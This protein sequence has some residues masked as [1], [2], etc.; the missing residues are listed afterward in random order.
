GAVVILTILAAMSYDPRLGWDADPDEA[1]VTLTHDDAPNRP[2]ILPDAADSKYQRTADEQRRTR[3]RRKWSRRLG[4]EPGAGAG[5]ARAA[6]QRQ[7][8]AQG[9][10]FVDLACAAGRGAGG[11]VV[12]GAR[13]AQCRTGGHDQFRVGRRARSGPDQDP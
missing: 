4:A 9:G 5:P 7:T 8:S 2:P 1:G 6:A 11:P 3:F 13:L 10:Y 12:V